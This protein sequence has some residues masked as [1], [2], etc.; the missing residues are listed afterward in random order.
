MAAPRLGSRRTPHDVGQGLQG[1]CCILIFY[2]FILKCFNFKHCCSCA[3]FSRCYRNQLSLN[4][5]IKSLEATFQAEEEEDA[6]EET[7]SDDDDS[8][9]TP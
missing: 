1:M 6:A 5:H 8:K 3:L 9:A 4:E 7:E 2:L